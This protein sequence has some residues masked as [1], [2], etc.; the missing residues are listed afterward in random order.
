MEEQTGEEETP[1]AEDSRLEDEEQELEEEEELI[2][3]EIVEL[4]E[5]TD[6]EEQVDVAVNV[7]LGDD[8]LIAADVDDGPA[9]ELIALAGDEEVPEVGPEEPRVSH[10]VDI[11][12]GD[13][14]EVDELA[15]AASEDHVDVLEEQPTVSEDW[16][17]DA[18]A[19]E[20]VPSQ[21]D[22][23]A[24]DVRLGR[25]TDA[26]YGD[27][28]DE[29]AEYAVAD[30]PDEAEYEEEEEEP[31][32]ISVDRLSDVPGSYFDRRRYDYRLAT[33]LENLE[34]SGN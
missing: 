10:A 6:A 13:E 2:D 4:E 31:S 18:V 3:A 5:V 14:D 26:D 9:D 12:E 1:Q 16:E 17:V 33:L 25:Y 23:L 22:T 21:P 30:E 24:P 34:K 20:D 29:R 32:D 19:A 11:E 15:T 27:V 7:E 28:V 8:T